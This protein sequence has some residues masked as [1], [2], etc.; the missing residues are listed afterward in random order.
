MVDAILAAYAQ[1][2]ARAIAAKDRDLAELHGKYRDLL[3]RADKLTAD[4]LEAENRAEKSA[5]APAT[6]DAGVPLVTNLYESDHG[7]AISFDVRGVPVRLAVACGSLDRMEALAAHLRA[8]RMPAP[9]KG[10]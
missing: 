7:L 2:L 5:A 4:L 6:E 9:G 10:E 1:D 3:A 8:G